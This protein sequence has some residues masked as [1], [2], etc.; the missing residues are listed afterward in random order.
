MIATGSRQ[1]GNASMT[2]HNF[3]L[4][5]LYYDAHVHSS[6]PVKYGIT[7][8]TFTSRA[9]NLGYRFSTKRLRC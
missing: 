9:G 2:I 1:G 7:S 8:V 5:R 4:L 3:S 6:D